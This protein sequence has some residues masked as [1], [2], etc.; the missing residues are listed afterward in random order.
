MDISTLEYLLAVGGQLSF[1]RA[2]AALFVSQS[3][4][5]RKIA[6]LEAELGCE[7]FLR[8]KPTLT[9]TESGRVAIEYAQTILSAHHAMLE[10]VKRLSRIESKTLRLGY[11]NTNQVEWIAELTRR[12]HSVNPD[13]HIQLTRENLPR[14]R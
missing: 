14:L 13:L 10:R 6:E 11:I 3:T 4:L 8:S 5:S 9:I 2:A 7:L 12:M 1:S